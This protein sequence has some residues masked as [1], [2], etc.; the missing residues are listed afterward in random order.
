MGCYKRVTSA[1]P[2]FQIKQLQ[3]KG[4]NPPHNPGYATIQPE[5]MSPPPS[6]VIQDTLHMS[7]GPAQG[8]G[9]LLPR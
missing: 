8:I 3:R 9:Y 5:D 4:H 7:L 1:R 6:V 2:Y